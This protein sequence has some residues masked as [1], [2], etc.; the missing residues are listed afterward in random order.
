MTIQRKLLCIGWPFLPACPQAHREPCRSLALAPTDRKFASASDDSTIKVRV[1]H[2]MTCNT[3]NPAWAGV[4]AQ[5]HIV[6]NLL[7]YLCYH[8]V[9][10]GIACNLSCTISGEC[11]SCSSQVL[12]VSGQIPVSFVY[13]VGIDMCDTCGSFTPTCTCLNLCL[14]PC[15]TLCADPR[16]CEGRR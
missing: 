3:C 9:G 10:S 11:R 5:P 13:R 1:G 14:C 2:N 16:L 7:K 6:V 8:L 12:P 15:T 4:S